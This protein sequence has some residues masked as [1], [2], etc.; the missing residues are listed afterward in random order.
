[1]NTNHRPNVLSQF[2][3]DRKGN[4]CGVVV[5][6]LVYDDT[7]S[8]GWSHVNKS[9]GDSFDKEKA[10]LIALNRA[11]NGWSP[12]I[13]VPHGVRKVL[14]KMQERATNYFKQAAPTTA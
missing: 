12:K 3:R 1:M 11:K 9:A 6:S 10:Y 4:P 7:F 2:V 13:E 8:V 14:A 5:A